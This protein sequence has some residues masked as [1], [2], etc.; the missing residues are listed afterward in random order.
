MKRITILSLASSLFLLTGLSADELFIQESFQDE[1]EASIFH[2]EDDFFATPTEAHIALVEETSEEIIE[3]EADIPSMITS[4]ETVVLE[5]ET[6]VVEEKVSVFSPLMQADLK[7]ASKNAA[8]VPKFNINLNQVFQG[9]P[10]IYSILF[11]MSMSTVF[12]WIYSLMKL[13]YA[14][15]LP[16]PLLKQVRQKLHS[17][18]Y[19]EALAI[20]ST[21]NNFFCKMLSAGIS[22]RSHG[23]QVMIENMKTEGKRATITFW[24]RLSFL[25]DIAIIAPMLGLLGTVLGMFYAFYDLNRSMESF[26]ILFDG[27]GI[28]VGTTVAGL[29]VAILALMLHSI[30]KYRLVRLLVKVENEAQSFASLLDNKSHYG[31]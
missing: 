21:Q 22:A 10:V 4:Q 5:K 2:L 11:L 24:Q 13:K 23:L 14:G 1:L 15:A 20:C 28:S 25:N 30:A 29:I 6:Q 19:D 16:E 26:S 17:N 12:I 31:Q 27:L 8:I 7:V 18:Q 3:S 9:A